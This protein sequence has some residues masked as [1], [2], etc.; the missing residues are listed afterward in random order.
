MQQKQLSKEDLTPFKMGL[1]SFLGNNITI[2]LISLLPTFYPHMN[3]LPPSPYHAQ[4]VCYPNTTEN[5]EV[6]KDREIQIKKINI[7]KSKVSK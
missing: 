4:Y 1:Y 6:Q 3:C 2:T 7:Q 5:S